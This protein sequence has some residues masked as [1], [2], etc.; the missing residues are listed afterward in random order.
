MSNKL[1]LTPEE[2]EV[3]RA[4]NRERARQYRERHRA[5]V[6]ANAR[7]WYREN[8]DKVEAIQ[9]RYWAKKAAEWQENQES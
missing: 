9:K 8:P 7:K 2:L 3:R 1:N 6:N 5:R 4:C